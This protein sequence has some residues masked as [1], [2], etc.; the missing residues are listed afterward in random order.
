MTVIFP[1]QLN[2]LKNDLLSHLKTSWNIIDCEKYSIFFTY[3]S[4]IALFSGDG[5]TKTI[6]SNHINMASSVRLYV[7]KNNFLNCCYD[8]L[9]Q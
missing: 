3:V 1:K 7:F 9:K 4:P 8:F 5:I 6:T 2:R